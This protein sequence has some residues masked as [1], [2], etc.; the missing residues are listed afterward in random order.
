M[1]L[2]LCRTEED[3]N[4]SQKSLRGLLLVVTILLTG[5]AHSQNSDGESRQLIIFH[6]GSLTVPFGKIIDGFKKEHPHVEVL[7]EI[8]G[9]RE[10]ARKISELHQP[11]DVFAS[12]DYEVIDE[13]LVPNFADWN[14]KFATNEMS[15]VFTNK[16]RRA[17]EINAQNWFNIL[18]D[19]KVSY[20]RSDPNAD[21]CGY[22]TILTMELAERYYGVN[23]LTDRLLRKNTEYIRP[24]EVDLLALL[25]VGELDY[26]FIYRS[27]AEQHS[28]RFLTLPDSINLKRAEYEQYYGQV[29]VELNGKKPGEKIRQVG[30]SMVY[31]VTIPGNAP[32]RDLAIAF[33]QYLLD[34]HKGMK[35][36]EEMGQPSVVPSECRSYD[37]LPE[38]LKPYATNPGH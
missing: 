34:K 19:D 6:A 11:C 15:I 10:C 27:V 8:A 14:L 23:G 29:S 26:I 12:A 16:S 35:I 4:L 18:Q 21:P 17:K 25:E 33:L 37:R 1:I 22:R 28:L 32:N 5:R 7:K 38:S 31:G 20:G 24:K 36:L 13:L 2:T 3:M 30:A 9:S